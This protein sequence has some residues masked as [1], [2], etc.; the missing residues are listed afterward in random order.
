VRVKSLGSALRSKNIVGTVLLVV[1]VA[2][3]YMYYTGDAGP[4]QAII[5]SIDGARAAAFWQVFEAEA[6]PLLKEAVSGGVRCDEGD[7]TPDAASTAHAS[8][9]SGASPDTLAQTGDEIETLFSVLGPVVDRP[10]VFIDSTGGELANLANGASVTYVDRDFRAEGVP[11]GD[12]LP[13]DI[14]IG[15]FDQSQPAL[16][17][18][19]LPMTD[20]TSREY[21]EQSTE[22]RAALSGAVGQ[23]ERLLAALDESG[24]LART[25]VVVTSDQAP[26]IMSG[27]GFKEGYMLEE[28]SIVDV[29]PT[30]ARV[31][32]IEEPEQA[33]GSARSDA[34][35]R[36]RNRL[37][38]LVSGLALI[39]FG[40]TD[41]VMGRSS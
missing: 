24:T 4:S 3:G 22:Y 34:L 10:T 29:A 26:L 20:A 5:I 17:F 7:L 32:G 25:A 23:V 41:Y 28:A 30:L 15:E 1:C 40:I 2:A 14:L 36:L 33:D 6:G 27:P 19:L 39:A 16:S 11:A 18:V 21:G 9:L 38:A 8:L 35:V 13:M 31:L 37:W 12:R